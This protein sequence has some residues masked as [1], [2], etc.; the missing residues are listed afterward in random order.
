MVW[1]EEAGASWEL[2]A[3]SGTGVK[4]KA[5]TA[6]VHVSLYN[7][8]EEDNSKQSKACFKCGETG[9]WRKDCPQK[10]PGNGNRSTGGGRS[11]T[12]KVSKDRKPPTH[13]K[14]HCALH[15]GLPGRGCSTWSCVALKYTPYEERVK[16]FRSRALVPNRQVMLYC[17]W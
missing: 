17:S 7:D 13:N 8:G 4:N 14:F 5:G 12:S 3:A 10:S 16:L 6:Q 9:H 15:K 2:L 11:A 1:L